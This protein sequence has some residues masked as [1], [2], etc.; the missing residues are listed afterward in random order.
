MPAMCVSGDV[1]VRFEMEP[2]GFVLIEA[3]G[4]VTL[5]D[6]L[7]VYAEMLAHPGYKPGMP[8]LLDNRR[9]KSVSDSAHIRRIKGEAESVAERLGGAR[10]AVVVAADAQFGMARMYQLMAEG[11]PLRIRVFRETSPAL[12]WL[13]AQGDDDFG[14]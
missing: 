2:R 5:E 6:E 11:G 10:C 14:S 13:F 8:I 12:R 4:E 1:S 9:R 7:P 3:I